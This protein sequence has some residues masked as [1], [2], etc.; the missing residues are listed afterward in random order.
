AHQQGI[1]HRDIKPENLFVSTT[2]GEHDFIK[3]LDFGVA[4]VAA[5]ATREHSPTEPLGVARIVD[6]IRGGEDLGEPTTLDEARPVNVTGDRAVGTPLY[7][8]PE[9]ARGGRGDARSDIYALGCVLYY[10]VTSRPVFN[11]RDAPSLLRA[12]VEREPTPPSEQLSQ[13]LPYYVETVIMRCLAKDPKLRYQNVE[14]LVRAIDLC[15]RLH[16]NDRRR[17]TTE[18]APKVRDTIIKVEEWSDQ[19]DTATDLSLD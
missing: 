2:A 12:H 4:S 10:M 14:A 9:V 16:D 17:G 11:E 13:P 1:I 18:I 15:R 19:G 5:E 8:S 7:I 3:V 6:D